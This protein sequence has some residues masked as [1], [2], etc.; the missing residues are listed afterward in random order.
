MKTAFYFNTHCDIKLVEDSDHLLNDLSQ[1][2]KFAAGPDLGVSRQID[3]QMFKI[4]KLRLSLRAN[5]IYFNI[6]SASELAICFRKYHSTL[7]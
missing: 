4:R 2:S 1:V 6:V 3:L 5:F 7:P